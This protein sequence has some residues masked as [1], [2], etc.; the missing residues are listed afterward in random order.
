MPVMSPD[1]RPQR[2]TTEARAFRP[3]RLQVRFKK[4]DVVDVLPW[5]ELIHTLDASGTVDGLPFMPEMLRYCGKRLMITKRL[6]RTCE[7]IEGGMRRIRNVVFLNDLRCD[8]SEHGG[9]Q[10]GCCM[11]WKDDWLRM[12]ADNTEQQKEGGH[13]PA[14]TFPCSF[15]DGNYICQSTEL[16]R[17]TSHLSLF[18]FG[19]YLRDLHAKTYS[20]REMVKVLSF[21]IKHRIRSRL[22]KKSH[23]FLEGSCLKTPGQSLHLQPGEWVRVK[24]PE[25]IAQTLNKEG[26]NR[27]LAFTVE[28]LPFC[29]HTFRVLT[30]LEKMMNESMRRLIPVEDTVILEGVTCDGCH[31]L[32]GG[33]PKNNYHFWREIWLE[34][35]KRTDEAQ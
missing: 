2:G 4:G 14:Y 1:I 7:D 12:P 24:T 26:K 29:G 35:L 33:C 13:P 34:R 10:K 9:C 3:S 20:A 23:R 28:M 32:R 31:I 15:G 25:A 27:G 30:R 5:D 8:G 17:A 22:E 6:E 18:D 11:L 19:S 21:A 16:L